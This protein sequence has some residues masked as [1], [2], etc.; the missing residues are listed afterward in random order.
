MKGHDRAIQ[1]D[2]CEKCPARNGNMMTSQ[3]RGSSYRRVEIPSEDEPNVD[4]CVISVGNYAVAD[5][6]IANKN[7]DRA[8]KEHDADFIAA[9]FENALPGCTKPDIVLGAAGIQYFCTPIN[10]A[11]DQFIKVNY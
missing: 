2:L 10:K 8:A 7:E 1:A 4:H 5:I 3:L 6:M 9:E 11:V